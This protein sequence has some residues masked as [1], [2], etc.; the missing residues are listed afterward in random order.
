MEETQIHTGLVGFFD[1]LGYQT[2]LENNDVETAT[3]EV[4]NVINDIGGTV[5]TSLLGVMKAPTHKDTKIVEGI[6]WL[7]FSDSILMLME[8]ADDNTY[9]WGIF[10]A[11][12]IKL[13]RQMFEFGLPLR[14]AIKKGKYLV[15]RSCFA[16][17]TIIEA[18]RTEMSLDLAAC[19]MDEEIMR[20][21]DKD[22]RNQDAVRELIVNYMTPLS[23]G[24]HKKIP[25]L[26]LVV[27]DSPSAKL[28]A[29]DIRQAVLNSFW[30]HNKDMTSS[31][32]IKANNTETF[33]RFLQHRFPAAFVTNSA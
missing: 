14:G 5:K 3:S 4:I 11:A 28:F 18:Y 9:E 27:P 29:A 1:I 25:L 24:Q 22:M 6:Q 13:C 20:I 12:A 2:F 8:W 15:S 7:V 30:S 16:G 26:N 10:T 19:A 23:G 31:A 17:R 33:L 32:E 21:I